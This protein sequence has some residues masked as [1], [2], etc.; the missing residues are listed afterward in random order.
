MRGLAADA[1]RRIF[2]NI[3]DHFDVLYEYAND[4]PAILKTRYEDNC[5]GDYRHLVIGT[6]GRC[7]HGWATADDHRPLEMD[8]EAAQA[9]RTQHVRP[10]TQALFESLRAGIRTNDGDR[11]VKSTLMSIMGRMSAYTG[12]Q[13]TWEMAMNSQENTM[14]ANLSW[15]MKLP[16]PELPVPGITK[17]T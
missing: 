10:G 8:L 5:F 15:D 14:P 13:I 1:P 11:M 16:V 3:F 7:T 6:K 4:M 12:Q 2:G 17:C 9:G